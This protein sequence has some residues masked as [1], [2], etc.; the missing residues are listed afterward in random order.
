MT[1]DVTRYDSQCEEGLRQQWKN[2]DVSDLLLRL[3]CVNTHRRR[4]TLTLKSR[5]YRSGE[6]EA[7]VDSG[8]D[9]GAVVR[10]PAL[11]GP[12]RPTGLKEN[13]PHCGKSVKIKQNIGIILSENPCRV[14][15][16]TV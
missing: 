2:C 8:A 3:L 11:V 15:C 7:C 12:E 4:E 9:A 14:S 6:L 10:A 16:N 5:R 13:S 1:L